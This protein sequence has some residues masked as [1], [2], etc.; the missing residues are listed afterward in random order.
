MFQVK[1]DMRS[2]RA[3]LER[4][5]KRDLPRVVG[6]SLDRTGASVKSLFSRRLRARLNL[7]KS[8]VDA[9]L[10][11]RRSSEIQTLT[12]LQ[13][14]RAWFALQTTGKPIPLRDFAARMTR[15]GV[16]FK[17]GRKGGRK[18]YTA[19]GQPGFIVQRLGGHVFVRKGPEPKGPAT[20]GI[21][22]VYGPA[23][24]QFL[25]SRVEQKILIEHAGKV[26]PVEIERNARFALKRRGG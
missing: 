12:A 10:K 11:I 5:E 6:R 15:S 26:W 24:P 2:A 13:A 21:R 25:A 3:Y 22:K 17:V 16:T 4:L 19:N 8:V 18:R 7:K 9:A 14:G 1:P 20:V 23:L